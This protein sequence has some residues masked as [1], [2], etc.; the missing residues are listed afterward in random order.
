[1]R[2]RLERVSGFLLYEG[3]LPLGMSF[4]LPSHTKLPYIIADSAEFCKCFSGISAVPQ[5]NFNISGRIRQTVPFQ[6]TH[7]LRMYAQGGYSAEGYFPVTL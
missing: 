1:M 4:L 5:G 6:Q 2:L 7:I 3:L